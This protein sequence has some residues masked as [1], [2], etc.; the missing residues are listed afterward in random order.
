MLIFTYLNDLWHIRI[1]VPV[2]VI[3]S[4]L[5]DQIFLKGRDFIF[6]FV[7]NILERMCN[8]W[9]IWKPVS[10]EIWISVLHTTWSLLRKKTKI[11]FTN[12][13]F[14]LEINICLLEINICLLEINICFPSSW[15]DTVTIW[16][17]TWNGCVIHHEGNIFIIIT[18]LLE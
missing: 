13:H 14:R 4:K 7:S 5:G 1:D 11:R 2:I 8:S 6:F 10:S 12:R 9:C 16:L 15:K 18:P 17:Q 3:R